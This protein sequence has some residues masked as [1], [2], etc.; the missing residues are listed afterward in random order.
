[1]N[2]SLLNNKVLGINRRNS[3]YI[4][5]YNLRKYYKTV[6]EKL[7]TKDF[8]K[9]VG[10]PFPKTLAVVEFWSEI[11]KKTNLLK[12]F[13]SFVIKPNRGAA[14]RGIMVVTR[15]EGEF[16]RL[17]DGKSVMPTDIYYHF[18]SILSGLYSLSE[19][20]DKAIV[21]QRIIPHPFFNKLTWNGTPD[22]RI[23]LFN[24]KPVMAMLRLPTEKSDGRANLHQ[25]AV[26]VGI[27]IDSGKTNAAIIKNNIIIFHPDTGENLIGLK[28]PDWKKIIDD[29]QKLADIIPLK[30]IGIDLMLDSEHGHLVVEANAR[31]GLNIQLANNMGLRPILEKIENEMN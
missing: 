15:N 5:P 31:P 14:G 20:P 13:D 24:K 8:S 26:G 25:G 12:K 28:I 9:K 7:K 17:A 10:I 6:D 4:L 27:D 23:V 19:L 2:F 18:S 29:A 1:M 22:I 3:N 21:E 30:Y 11:T 16:W